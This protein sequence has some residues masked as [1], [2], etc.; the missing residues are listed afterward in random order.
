MLMFYVGFMWVLCKLYKEIIS[1]EIISKGIISK[2][3]ISKPN[4]F[5]N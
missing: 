5:K 3:I 2:G 4:K 1:K